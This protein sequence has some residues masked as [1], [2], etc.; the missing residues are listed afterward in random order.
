MGGVTTFPMANVMPDVVEAMLEELKSGIVPRKVARKYGVTYA[1]VNA[2][3]RANQLKFQRGRAYGSSNPSCQKVSPE[4]VLEALRKDDNMA[5]VSRQFNISRERVRQIALR[6][7]INIKNQ[8]VHLR[9]QN[10][11]LLKD[12]INHMK[13][14]LCNRCGKS[15][16]SSA[17]QL[18]MCEA[19]ATR[20]R[21]VNTVMAR[22][23][24]YITTG[25]LRDLN[26]AAWT[27]REFGITLDE[28]RRY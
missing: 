15:P 12:I 2:L 10:E 6:G 4:D 11:L 16:I 1:S 27:V 13:S 17:T 18:R 8:K 19:C 5:A 26:Q 3:A 20:R 24:G 23:R 22:V 21:Y 7:G 28:I 14:D 25:K 9:E